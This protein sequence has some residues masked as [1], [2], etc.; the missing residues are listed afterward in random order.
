MI[1]EENNLKEHLKTEVKKVREELDKFLSETKKIIYKSEDLNESLKKFEKEENNTMKTLSYISKINE[2]E[3]EMKILFQELMKSLKFSYNEKE[4]KINY[5]KYI[6]NGILPP[7]DIEFEEI[8]NN[9]IKILWK[10][11]NNNLDLDNGQIK[12]KVEIRK[13]NQNEAFKQV[14]EGKD[15]NCLINKLNANTNYEIR[16]FS[17]YKDMIS[18]GTI[19]KTKTKN[20]ISLILTE[21]DKEEE[22]LEIILNWCGYKN[23]ELIYRATE[24]GA[25]S[26]IFHKKCDNQGPTICLIKNEN[27]NIF[28]GYASISWNNTNGYTSAPDSFLFTLT[29]IHNTSPTKFPNSNKDYSLFFNDKYGPTFGGGHDLHIDTQILDSKAD[30]SFPHSYKDTL[31]KGR[32][33]FTGNMNSKSFKLKELEV[34]KLTK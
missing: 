26:E 33:V 12:F 2:N 27:G 14:Y 18:N 24:D 7:K 21:I 1:K 23:M 34:F 29:N 13:E 5:E 11:D 19:A 31:G 32:S 8:G 20:Y 4:N 25:T 28:G 17:I 3:N 10:F 16:I 22:F 6:F 30:S 15:N 9:Y